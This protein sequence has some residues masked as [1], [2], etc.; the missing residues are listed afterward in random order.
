M[1]KIGKVLNFM[2]S[3]FLIALLM[4]LLTFNT[5]VFFMFMQHPDTVDYLEDK[6]DNDWDMPY[7]NEFRYLLTGIDKDYEE[8]KEYEQSKV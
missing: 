2:F 3:I 4:S 6:F 7:E 5:Y 8:Y 1:G